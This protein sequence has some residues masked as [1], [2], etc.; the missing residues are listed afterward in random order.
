MRW[1]RAEAQPN[2]ETQNKLN[3]FFFSVCVIFH[4]ESKSEIRFKLW[5]SEVYIDIATVPNHTLLQLQ[6]NIIPIF[7]ILFKLNEQ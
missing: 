7:C 1:W 5:N 2:P 4:A 6:T 3:C